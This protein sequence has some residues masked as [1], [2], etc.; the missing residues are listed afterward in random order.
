MHAS[1]RN[2][3]IKPGVAKTIKNTRCSALA[4][5]NE[6]NPPE[7]DD[8][9]TTTTGERREWLKEKRKESE[10]E[11]RRLKDLIRLEELQMMNRML[12]MHTTSNPTALPEADTV[13]EDVRD[14]INH[15]E[16]MY[17]PA[18]GDGN[19]LSDN[20]EAD[21]NNDRV[22]SNDRVANE[23]AALTATE[24][25]VNQTDRRTEPHAPGTVPTEATSREP[26]TCRSRNRRRCER[27]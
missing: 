10:R 11:G 27:G 9:R 12:A 24:S 4:I 26:S 20:D 2:P 25:L 8:G 5:S 22:E 14:R 21:V 3:R 15:L 18:T 1:E 16:R 23:H 13:A 6:W 19:D 7:V 17:N